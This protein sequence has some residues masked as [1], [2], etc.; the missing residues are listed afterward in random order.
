MDFSGVDDDTSSDGRSSSPIPSLYSFHSSLDG[1]LMLRNIY[2]RILNNQN[3]TYFLPADNEEHRRL[4]LQH[5]IYTIS[6][7]GLYSAPDLVRRALQPRPWSSPAVLDV[8]CGSGRWAIDMAN[9]FPHCEVVGIDLVP[10]NVQVPLPTNCRFEIDDAN[11]GFAHYR[12]SFDVVQ[13]RAVSSGIRDYP[14]FLNELAEVLRPGGVLLLGDG[15]MQIFDETRQPIAYAEE[16]Q[17]GFSWTHRIFF[18]AYNA[19]KSKGGSVDSPSMNPTWLRAIDSLTDVGWDK[20]FIP[21]G[22][23]C[24]AS[25]RERVVAEM[26]RANALSYISGM[27][28]LLLSEGYLPERVA[29]M[30]REATAELRELRINV[31]SRWS[32]AWAVKKY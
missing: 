23:W 24:Y 16:G 31:Y 1:R 6:L 32:F 7:N 12:N 17:P 29:T 18:A 13:A 10:P 21:M 20:V 19:M 14:W 4:D 5:H 8:G 26:L 22:P 30:Q 2:G 28:P 27:G 15:D 9:E 25:E 3:D 11:L